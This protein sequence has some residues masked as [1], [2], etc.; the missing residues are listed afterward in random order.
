MNRPLVA[1]FG[2]G[3]LR[4]SDPGYARALELG[5]ALGRAGAD[6]MTGG[7]G[8]VMEA[9][10]RGCKERGGRAWGVTVEMFRARGGANRWVDEVIHAP[11]LFDRLRH[12]IE[13][14]S[15]F[16]VLPGSLGTLA[17][18]FLT[19]NLLT[20]AGRRAA[21]LVLC[22]EDWEDELA[23]LRSREW[24]AAE[25]FTSIRTEH[26]PEAAVRIVLEGVAAPR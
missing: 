9:A 1:V 12:L 2:S 3:T 4:E 8:G 16:I 10:S 22:G 7:Y 18:L 24:V 21:P 26:D 13:R 23:L 25:L 20:A 19:W 6:V 14:P 5:R 15:G 17:E 11:D